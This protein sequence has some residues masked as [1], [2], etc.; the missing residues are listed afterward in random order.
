MKIGLIGLGVL[1]LVVMAVVLP[2]TLISGSDV[3]P[4]PYSYKEFNK[5]V[6]VNGSSYKVTPYSMEI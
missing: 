6:F 5:F 2:L 1:I 3:P 4:D